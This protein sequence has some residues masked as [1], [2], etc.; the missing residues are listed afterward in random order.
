MATA[1]IA[2]P[3][4]YVAPLGDP[5]NAAANAGG[6]TVITASPGDQVCVGFYVQGDAA[7]FATKAINMQFLTRDTTASGAAPAGGT[8]IADCTTLAIDTGNADYIGFD[9]PTP[10]GQGA[11]AGGLFKAGYVLLNLNPPPTLDAPAAPDGAYFGELCYDVSNDAC[12]DFDLTY[13]NIGIESVIVDQFGAPAAGAIYDAL[14]ISVRPPN[15]ACADATVVGSGAGANVV[16]PYDTACAT[17]S[18]ITGSCDLTGD[19]WFEIDVQCDGVLTISDA[20]GGANLAVYPEGTACD[21]ANDSDLGC[22]GIVIG[23]CADQAGN[24]LVSNGDSYLVRIGGVADAAG[25][26]TVNCTACCTAGAP[27]GSATTNAECGVPADPC[28]LSFCNDGEIAGDLGCREVAVDPNNAGNNTNGNACDDGNF[29]LIDDACDNGACVG[30]TD[31]LSC[32]DENPCTIDACC[33][34]AGDVIFSNSVGDVTC[35]ASDSCQNVDINDIACN[36]L[37]DCPVGSTDCAGGFCV[38]VA[39]PSLCLEVETDPGTN[40]LTGVDEGGDVIVNVIKGSGTTAI[41]AAQFFLQYDTSSLDFVSIVPGGGVFN[42]VS[43]EFVDEVAGT[44]DYLVGEDPGAICLGEKDE[45]LI[46]TI[47]FTNI[48][49]CKGDGVCFRPHNPPTRLGAADGEEIC[50]LGHIRPDGTCGL[51]NN[52]QAEP[53]CTGAFSVDSTDPVV[54]CPDIVEFGNADCGKVTRYVTWPPITAADNCDGALPVNC[55]IMH[56]GGVNVDHLL[57]GGGNFPP[58]VTTIECSGTVD[59]CGNSADC[60][61]SVGN[62]GL[63]GLHVDVELSPTMDAG[64]ITRGIEFSVSDC[65]SIANPEPVTTCADVDF[66]FPFNIPGHGEAQAKIPPGNW[67]CIEARDPLHTLNATCDV[68]CEDIPGKGEVWYASFKGSKDLSDTCHWLVN[69]NLNGEDGDGNGRIDVLDYV[70]YL[71]CVANNPNPGEDTPCGT[72]GPHCDINGDGIVSLLDFAFILVNIFNTDKAGCD[73]VC[74]PTVAAGEVGG[75]RESVTVR[76]LVAMGM[77][78]HAAAA[79]VDGNGIV[80]LTDMA[81]YLQGGERTTERDVR[82]NKGSRSVR[83]LR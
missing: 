5:T 66:G 62:S 53:C 1:A 6:T 58:G 2:Q 4:M 79:D 42:T 8:V 71:A 39:N 77:G 19:V 27:A 23:D 16:T 36:D 21:P 52:P 15:D 45:A 63:N 43:V 80:N 3:R 50:P 67:L 31:N 51:D 13:F 49:A 26:F 41:C 60:S 33:E 65:G 82:T 68:S 83:G 12:G 25:D 72:A 40:C 76:E 37:N 14:T 46:A 7:P 61:F 35:D 55:T 47:T 32:V 54:T 64:P 29:C 20:T 34:T 57:M 9:T 44:I 30:P 22:G 75:A 78:A 17:D 38:C 18:G 56:N 28:L 70:T 11:C 69:G 24:P 48:A 74:S 10:G 59:N 81:L 73:A